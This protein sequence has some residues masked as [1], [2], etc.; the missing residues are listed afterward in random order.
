MRV[1]EAMAA[2]LL[3]DAPGVSAAIVSWTILAG[4]VP[5]SCF[6]FLA[7]LSPFPL[8]SGFLLLVLPALGAAA[9]RLVVFCL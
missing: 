4:T 6:F 8:L 9:C 1:F 2:I 5:A 3:A 7:L